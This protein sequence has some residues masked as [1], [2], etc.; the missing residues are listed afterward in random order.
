MVAPGSTN[1]LSLQLDARLT[2]SPTCS[3]FNPA[4][5]AALS[6]TVSALS[7]ATNASLSC[8]ERGMTYN[9]TRGQ[10]ESTLAMVNCGW[11][12]VGLDVNAAS[13]CGLTPGSSSLGA[14]CVAQ[15]NQGYSQGRAT[16][17]TCGSNGM[18]QGSLSCPGACLNV[19]FSVLPLSFTFFSLTSFLSKAD[20][21]PAL[22]SVPN[23]VVATAGGNTTGAVRAVTC[24]SEYYAVGV[25]SVTCLP[26][27]VWS[28]FPACARKFPRLCPIP[29]PSPAPAPAPPPAPPSPVFKSDLGRA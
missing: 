14:T 23:G 16:S 18:W 13:A 21:C 24:N 20:P 8:G 3:C 26:T 11:R 5:Q 29:R 7:A 9:R 4:S 12:I 27:G 1:A 15:C 25:A 10:C 6:D 28:S 17:F 22:G 19:F 2:G